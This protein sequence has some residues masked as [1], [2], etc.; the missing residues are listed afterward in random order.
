LQNI[1][2]RQTE[3]AATLGR[4]ER[5][6]GA[7]LGQHQALRDLGRRLPGARPA[8]TK[9]FDAGE[10]TFLA[11]IDALAAGNQTVKGTI[12]DAA[13]L[14]P[15]VLD[16]WAGKYRGDVFAIR[17]SGQG[18][19]ERM[20]CAGTD[21]LAPALA[22][23]AAGPFTEIRIINLSEI[24]GAVLLA[25]NIIAVGAGAAREAFE[26]ALAGETDPAQ[27]ERRLAQYAEI[28]ARVRS[29]WPKRSASPFDAS[30]QPREKAVA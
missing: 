17:V 11:I 8:N 24:V 21:E 10:A 30:Y 28:E 3:L 26:A 4:E 12:E 6:F 20:V 27:R 13:G 29:A 5:A 7:F 1:R 25:W 14:R 15:V 18:R 22:E 19:D 16:M 2:F 9:E 23:M